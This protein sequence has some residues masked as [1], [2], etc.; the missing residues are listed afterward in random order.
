MAMTTRIATTI[1]AVSLYLLSLA[2]AMPALADPGGVGS[3]DPLDAK[4]C[5]RL[6]RDE[7]SKSQTLTN[8]CSEKIEVAWCH[9]GSN[10]KGTKDSACGG[11]KYFRQHKTLEPGKSVSNRFSLP[12]DAQVYFGACIG[13]YS[14]LRPEG[15]A[16]QYT[17]R[18][19]KEGKTEEKKKPPSVFHA[20]FNSLR[21]QLR[22]YDAASREA[23][24]KQMLELIDKCLEDEKSPACDEV[25]EM[26]KRQEKA[27]G[28]V[29]G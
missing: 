28:G 20:I 5:V 29:R 25:D 21:G 15:N 6:T 13:G 3:A 22:E 7:K 14:S 11:E 16:G 27:A 4:N 18:P 19:P 26:I 2:I 9:I 8:T 23:A 1:R 24:K 17:C 12:L 10:E